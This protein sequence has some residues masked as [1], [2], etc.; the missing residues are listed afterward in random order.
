ML[1]VMK[2]ENADQRRRDQMAIAA[3][4]FCHPKLATVNTTLNS[5]PTHIGM[6]KIVTIPSGAF[7]PASEMIQI[8]NDPPFLDLEPNPELE[9]EAS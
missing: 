3:A 7:V 2:D 8:K 5:S 4:P 1:N 6:V 9:P